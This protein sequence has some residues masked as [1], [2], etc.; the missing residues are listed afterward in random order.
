[1]FEWDADKEQVNITKHGVDFS[2]AK[3]AFDDPW[4]IITDD[5]KHSDSEPRY[6]CIGYV[7]GAGVLTVRF[8][9][10]GGKIRIFGAGYWRKE[11]D[12]YEKRNSHL[13]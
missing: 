7:E 6:F 3:Q 10:R 1:M 13:H 9:F 5:A 8:T 2:T 12:F 4:R 11:R